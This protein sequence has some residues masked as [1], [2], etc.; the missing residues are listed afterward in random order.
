MPG[1]ILVPVETLW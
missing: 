1:L